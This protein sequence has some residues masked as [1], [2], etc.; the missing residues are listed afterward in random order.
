MPTTGREPRQERSRQ[1]RIPAAQLDELVLAALARAA[2]PL[3][4]YQIIAA[5]RDER[6]TVAPPPIY[7]AL[8]RLLDQGEIERIEMLSAYRI[9]IVEKCIHAICDSCGGLSSIPASHAVDALNAAMKHAGFASPRLSIEATGRC[10]RC[11][12]ADRGGAG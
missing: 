2:A 10:A 8:K 1:H 12:L 9:R 5:L 3:S 6:K 4:A 11:E 7:R